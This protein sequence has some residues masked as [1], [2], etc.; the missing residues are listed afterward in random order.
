VLKLP[1]VLDTLSA[2]GSYPIGTTPEEFAADSKR[3]LEVVGQVC[4]TEKITREERD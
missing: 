3:Q 1:E 4:K 2:V